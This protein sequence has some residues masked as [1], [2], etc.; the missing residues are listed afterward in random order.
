MGFFPV[1]SFSLYYGYNYNIYHT[2]YWPLYVL[3]FE[4][5]VAS[6]SNSFARK[7]GLTT[8]TFVMMTF[9]LELLLPIVLGTVSLTFLLVDFR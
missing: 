5:F 4:K 6:M 7:T 3:P 1:A 9:I 2:I 8:Q